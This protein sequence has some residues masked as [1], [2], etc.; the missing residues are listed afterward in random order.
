V[1]LF[2][3]LEDIDEQLVAGFQLV[4]RAATDLPERPDN[5]NA[6]RLEMPGRRLL[7]PA[8]TPP[9]D[10]AELQSGVA[11]LLRRFLLDDRAGS[12]LNDRH[13]DNVARGVVLLAHAELFAD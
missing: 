13:R 5:R 2:A 6:G 1:D 10:E 4:R 12:R 7:R 9:L 8:F 3:D 11:V